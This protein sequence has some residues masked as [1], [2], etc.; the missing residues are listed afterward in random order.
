[1]CAED[2]PAL[3]LLDPSVAAIRW[4][5]AEAGRT[6]ELKALAAELVEVFQKLGVAREACAALLM[7]E[8]AARAE[9]VT[10]AFLAQLNDY[11][12]R[13]RSQPGL[14]FSPKD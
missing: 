3:R 13:V 14:V 4:D 9:A 10:L 1:M 8:A 12:G 6:H 7:F 5:F 11:L 2:P